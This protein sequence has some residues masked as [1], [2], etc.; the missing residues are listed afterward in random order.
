M[1][2]LSLAS[3]GLENKPAVVQCASQ[4]A[5]DAWNKG[6]VNNGP[7][8]CVGLTVGVGFVLQCLMQ[9]VLVSF[10]SMVSKAR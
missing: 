1:Q 8:A 6:K 2:K 3:V 7:I 5:L 4:R 9:C 10:E